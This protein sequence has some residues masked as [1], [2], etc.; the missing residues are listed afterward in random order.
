VS[1]L[2]IVGREL[3][4]PVG[5]RSLGPTDPRYAGRYGGGPATRDGV[6][7]Q[8]TA[9]AWLAGA[10]S[11]ALLRFGGEHGRDRALAMLDGLRRHLTDAGLGSV[12][13]IFDA[14]PPFTPRGCPWQAWSVAEFLRAWRSVTGE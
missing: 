13:E 9:W 7:H 8:G 11:D 1:V 14:D 10:Y 6:Y 5:L 4:T 3:E 2:D 12:S